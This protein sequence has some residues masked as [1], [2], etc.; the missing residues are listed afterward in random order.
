MEEE[1]LTHT[2][3]NTH[4]HTYTHTHTHTHTHTRA[5][6]FI[7]IFGIGILILGVHYLNNWSPTANS[8][9]KLSS[10]L[11]YGRIT[12]RHCT[13]W[14]N[15]ASYRWRLPLANWR[16]IFWFL[17]DFSSTAARQFRQ[18]LAIGKLEFSFF[19][20]FFIPSAYFYPC[21]MQ[22]RED[23]S[24]DLLISQSIIFSKS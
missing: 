12:S 20:S 8:I 9:H 13:L 5:E 10:Q 7:S 11:E 24:I 3:T 21:W 2:H 18:L 22:R 16:I 19:L 17:T 23:G 1:L 4:T 6:V 14:L 15:S